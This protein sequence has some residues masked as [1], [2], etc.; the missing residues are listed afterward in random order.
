MREAR[1]SIASIAS[2]RAKRKSI[3]IMRAKRA[4]VLLLVS[5]AALE[6]ASESLANR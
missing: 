6:S 2:M 5:R 4:K 1:E 3:A